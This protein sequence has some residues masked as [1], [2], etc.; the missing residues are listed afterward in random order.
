ML[1]KADYGNKDKHFGLQFVKTVH[2]S[3]SSP[4]FLYPAATTCGSCSL[5]FLC[6]FARPYKLQTV[7]LRQNHCH[8]C[9]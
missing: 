6:A 4:P 3:A 2:F 8:A 9:H 7:Y 5:A 1:Q